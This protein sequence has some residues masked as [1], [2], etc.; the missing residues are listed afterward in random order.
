MGWREKGSEEESVYVYVSGSTSSQVEESKRGR[1]KGRGP[2][3]VP[4]TRHW[5]TGLHPSP[6]LTNSINKIQCHNNDSRHFIYS[7]I[8]KQYAQVDSFKSW[9]VLCI[10]FYYSY[11]FHDKA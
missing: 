1:K 2:N 3:P 11:T 10:R 4:Q 7:L 8:S 5:T 9:A 6:G